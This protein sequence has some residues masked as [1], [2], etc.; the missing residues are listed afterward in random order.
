MCGKRPRLK[1]LE[2]RK[3]LLL[4]ESDLN[5]TRLI[6]EWNG[7]KGE[8]HRLTRQVRTVGSFASL[9]AVVWAAFS[10]R[11]RGPGPDDRNGKTSWGS[12]LLN[13]ARTGASLWVV[14]KSCFR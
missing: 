9:A 8:V 6:Q 7:L 10:A 11:R 14:L 4:A 13:C 12:K 3:Q 2:A 5:R 1:P